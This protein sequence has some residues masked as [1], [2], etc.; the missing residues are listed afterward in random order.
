[1]RCG[2]EGVTAAAGDRGRAMEQHQSQETR[3]TQ[4]SD[5]GRAAPLEGKAMVVESHGEK[6]QRESKRGEAMKNFRGGQHML[7]WRLAGDAR[8]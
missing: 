1:M 4:S 8:E 3:A 5:R 6:K 7:C 2:N